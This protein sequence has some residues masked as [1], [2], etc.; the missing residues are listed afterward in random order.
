V[1]HERRPLD[2]CKQHSEKQVEAAV[3]RAYGPQ[4]D[5]ED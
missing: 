5:E 3:Q 1:S 4:R 2:A